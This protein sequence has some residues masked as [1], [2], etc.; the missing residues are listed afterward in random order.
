MLRDAADRECV[1]SGD[2]RTTVGGD[3]I[4][5]AKCRE[6]TDG[7][8]SVGLTSIEYRRRERGELLIAIAAMGQLM[9]M[10]IIARNRICLV[11]I[12]LKNIE[13]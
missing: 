8:Y 9:S 12:I 3:R 11:E 1:S 2:D 7:R 6:N 5:G 13:L 4:E 10:T